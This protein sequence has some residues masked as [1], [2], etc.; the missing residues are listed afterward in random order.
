MPAAWSLIW[1]MKLQ[2][3]VILLLFLFTS[4][5]FAQPVTGTWRGKIQ[6][7]GKRNYQVELKLIRN[8]DSLTGTSYYYNSEYQYSRYLVKGYFDPSGEIIWW[9]DQLI[10]NKGS[11][12]ISSDKSAFHFSADFNCPGEDI[13]KLDGTG[14]NKGNGNELEVHLDK[15]K[16]PI[17]P[18][19][20]DEVIGNYPYYAY[21]PG[22]I[23]SVAESSLVRQPLQTQP[24]EQKT[25]SKKKVDPPVASQET[26]PIS[27]PKKETV[28]TPP[29]KLT[30]TVEEKFVAR[31]K[32]LTSEIPV[33][34]DSISLS[35][36]DHAE[37]DGDS[38]A[39]FLNGKMM[40]QHVLLKAEPFT[41]KLAVADLAPE[42]EMIMVA[43]NLGSI[44]PNTSLMIAWCN[45]LRYEA[46]LES[47]EN[48]SA[49]IR[50]VKPSDQVGI[51]K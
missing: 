31:K 11:A 4:G 27:F 26:I 35:F 38:I 34:G 18:D 51:K 3:P 45:G 43:E 32:I 42:N 7:Q 2:I 33:T 8:A 12:M 25:G 5:A 19:E 47:T 21:T 48:S 15:M 23:D 28:P 24:K 29:V 6:V 22:L 37:I 49:M 17:F 46:R 14:T 1:R 9:D 10:E 20:W 13:M 40:Y 36:Y 16:K 30:A 44:P 41:F 50:F 39:L